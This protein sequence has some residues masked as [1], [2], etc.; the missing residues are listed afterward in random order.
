MSS[1]N[2]LS[3]HP[4]KSHTHLTP[5][6]VIR[7]SLIYPCLVPNMTAVP[8][9]P[10]DI[11]R[12]RD[13]LIKCGRRDMWLLILGLK[14][15]C[16]SLFYSLGTLCAACFEEARLTS[17]RMR[18]HIEE[19]IGAPAN[20][21]HRLPCSFEDMLDSP[22]PLEPLADSSHRSDPKQHQQNCPDHQP[23]GCEK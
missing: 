15:L 23:Q 13:C 6:T 8:L 10:A 4:S 18:G 12:N 3:G 5:C 16:S 9:T 7:I 19:N 20:R 21:Q 22:A 14:R 11:S 2:L 1:Y 17:C